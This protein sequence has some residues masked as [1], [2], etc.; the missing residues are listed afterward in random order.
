MTTSSAVSTAVSDDRR[1]PLGLLRLAL[2]LDAAVTGVNGAAYLAAAPL[3]Q[4]VLGLPA[5]ALRGVGLFLL[6]FAVG[7]W[8]LGAR[9]TIS[10]GAASAIVAVNLLWAVD[11]VAVAVL[12][13]GAPTTI[14]TVWIVLQAAVVGGFAALQ[15][16]GIRRS[17][18][19]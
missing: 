6:A 16:L 10:T 4:D 17:N 14:G 11:S 8:F 1:H 18:S 19:S 13:W 2:K 12:G 15:W 9:S 7:V 5:G 3:V